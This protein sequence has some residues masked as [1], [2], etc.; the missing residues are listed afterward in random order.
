MKTT[1]KAVRSMAV[2]LTTLAIA[3]AIVV[4]APVSPASAQ[5]L[6]RDPAK[7]V[8]PDACG[9]CHKS[10]VAA[11]KETHHSTTFKELP[12]KK[13]AREI[14]KNMG[15]KRKSKVRMERK[16]RKCQQSSARKV[17]KIRLT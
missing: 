8:G 4:M 15:L 6:R 1:A 13:E 16:Q 17:R 10:S 14:A 3:W 11:W 12:R 9:E 7:V 5:E 2:G